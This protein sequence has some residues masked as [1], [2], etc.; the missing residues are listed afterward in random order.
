MLGHA[1]TSFTTPTFAP[2]PSVDLFPRRPLYFPPQ[3][4]SGVYPL[5]SSDVY[6]E[7]EEEYYEEEEEEVYEE[8]EEEDALARA[9]QVKLRKSSSMFRKVCWISWWGQMILSTVS[10]TILLFS[11]ALTERSMRGNIFGNGILMA[12]AGIGMS[13][14][15]IFWTW[16]NIVQA[17][18]WSSRRKPVEPEAARSKIRRSLRLGVWINMIGML[19][20][21]IGAEQIVGTLVAKVLY[22]QGFAPAS[23]QFVSGAAAAEFSAL[24]FRALDVFVVQANTNAILSHFSSLVGNLF[25][26]SASHKDT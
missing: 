4:I 8:E 9:L 7:E 10:A 19:L 15:S 22:S 21:L 18:R 26:L 11:N 1:L 23:G 17:R 5:Q 3:R 6:D 12:G 20:A 13:G 14:L 24:Q 2:T 16:G 25:L